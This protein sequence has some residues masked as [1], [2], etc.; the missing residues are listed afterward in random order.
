MTKLDPRLQ[1]PMA[2]RTFLRTVA[3]AGGVLVTAAVT[4]CGSSTKTAASTVAPATTAGNSGTTVKATTATAA[5]KPAAGGTF[6]ATKE[7]AISFSY[8]ADASA[9]G[10]VNNPYVAVWIETAD[11]TPVR[12]VSVNYQVGRGDRW[13]NELQRWFRST[14]GAPA[15]LAT[16]S[17][18]TRVPGDYKVVW[19]GTDD[20]KKP[21]AQG[22]YFVCIESAREHGPYSLIRETVTIN[23]TAAVKNLSDQGELHKATVELKARS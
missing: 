5:A 21:V 4:A 19:D 9:G 10:R 12:T 14:N 17:S 11:G 7:V 15:I 16:V 18:A 2:R 1:N 13:L 8:T 3:A 6:D 23:K 20:T 22:E